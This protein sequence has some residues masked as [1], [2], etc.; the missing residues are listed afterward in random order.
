MGALEMPTTSFEKRPL[1]ATIESAYLVGR[2]SPSPDHGHR[3]IG[4]GMWRDL[5]RDW[6]LWSTA[7]R[8]TALF[9]LA[10]LATTPAFILVASYVQAIP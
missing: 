5:A 2:A 3:Q 10:A 8:T 7:E 1:G 9:L 6:C 4:R